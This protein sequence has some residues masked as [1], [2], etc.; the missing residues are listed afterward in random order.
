MVVFIVEIF[1]L[2]FDN[3]GKKNIFKIWRRQYGKIS[4]FVSFL[5]LENSKNFRKKP[6]FQVEAVKELEYSNCLSNSAAKSV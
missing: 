6:L 5:R 3:C 1:G 2:F 4:E